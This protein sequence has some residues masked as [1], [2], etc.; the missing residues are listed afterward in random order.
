MV[1]SSSLFPK[2]GINSYLSDENRNELFK[3]LLR[4]ISSLQVALVIVIIGRHNTDVLSLST[5]AVNDLVM[6]HVTHTTHQGQ[7]K[8]RNVD[9]DLVVLAVATVNEL[10]F[11]ECS[12]S[13]P[14][15]CFWSW[16][17][18]VKSTP[19]TGCDTTS[20][21]HGKVK[22]SAWECWKLSHM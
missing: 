4:Q 6:L 16:T 10:D 1:L 8:V 9:T 5:T 20:S 11:W 17:R 18:T 3:F 15:Y 13:C 7:K 21:F 14:L 19:W 22:K 12:N 2:I